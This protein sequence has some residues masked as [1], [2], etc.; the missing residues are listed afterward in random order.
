ML[1]EGIRCFVTRRRSQRCVATSS[2]TTGACVRACHSANAYVQR[3]TGQ[4]TLQQCTLSHATQPTALGR[5]HAAMQPSNDA[6]S[7][8]LLGACIDASRTVQHAPCSTPHQCFL[9]VTLRTY[10]CALTCEAFAT[11]RS[12]IPIR[13]AANNEKKGTNSAKRWTNNATK[14][15]RSALKCEVGLPH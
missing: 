5:P 15:Y 4:R 13:V 9:P 8:M 10:R 6:A 7:S 12:K 1:S 11:G 3:C 2:R 14:G